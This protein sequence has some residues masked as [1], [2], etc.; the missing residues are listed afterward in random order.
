MLDHLTDTLGLPLAPLTW[1]VGIPGAFSGV[2]DR[3]DDT[4]H[5]FTRVTGGAAIAPGADRPGARPGRLRG[6]RRVGGRRGG[7]RARR[8]GRQRV[9]RRGVLARR[10]ASRCCS[11]RRPGTSASGC[12]WTRCA[13]S[14]RRPS[15]A[16]T[17]DGTPRP[18]DAPFAA[19]VFK[20]QANMDPR[21]R[22]RVAFVRICSGRFE[23]GMRVD[24]A[25]TGRSLALSYA[26]EVFGQD[27]AVLDEA[28]PGD[29]V[30]V[31]IGG[32][33]RVGDTLYVG[34]QVRF[35][36]D[37]DAHAGVLR[38]DLQPRRQP[39]QA[40]PPRP[41]AARPGGRR[42]R[43][44]A[45]A[46]PGPGARAGGRRPDAV[47]GRRRAPADRVRRRGAARSC[48]RGR[49]L[50]APTPRAPPRCWPT[51]A[52]PTSSSAATGR[53]S[54]SSRTA[55]CW[56]ASPSATRTSRLERLIGADEPEG[57]GGP[58]PRRARALPGGG[59]LGSEAGGRKSAASPRERRRAARAPR[60][61][62]RARGRRAG[63]GGARA[64]GGVGS[65]AEP[66]RAPPRR[67]A[68]PPQRLAADAR[69]WSARARARCVRPRVASSAG[70]SRPSGPAMT[71]AAMDGS[72]LSAP[73]LVGDSLW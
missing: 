32:D 24:N 4:F 33:V 58:A 1:P 59:S 12:C 57:L 21:H 67:R 72:M 29:V 31:V 34:P 18:V 25:R 35:P 46:H 65:Y 64:A 9:R 3:R 49:P 7:A 54:R 16:P 52:Q 2:I 53:S 50:A 47:R 40:V 30:G 68:G 8:R 45:R 48:C 28:F 23:R 14:R 43:A 41:R 44:A 51:P 60:A 20:V 66:R 70:W 17:D 39:P 36:A 71:S 19:L 69:A 55:S 42:P 15:R 63:V 38:D 56:S 5:R 6:R 73:A 62:R 11:A 27:R 26:H 61:A 22:D 10:A 37:P 13:T